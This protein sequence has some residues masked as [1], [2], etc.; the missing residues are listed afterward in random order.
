MIRL[1]LTAEGVKDTFDLPLP[2]VPAEDD[3]AYAWYNKAGVETGQIR[4]AGMT[5]PV[6]SLS[7]YIT[8]A[9]VGSAEDM[10]KLN[11]LAK[12]VYRMHSP[13]LRL[14]ACALDAESI[15]GL[16][17]VLRAADSLNSY[18]LIEDVAS[19]RELGGW[20]VE[21]G[22]LGIDFP[23]NVRPYL[24]YVGI[25]AEYYASHGGAYPP[26]GYV[27]RR[28]ASQE[29]AARTRPTLITVY[30]HTL[31]APGTPSKICC[32]QLPATD[33]ELE[34]AKRKMDVDSFANAFIFKIEFGKPY[35][36]ELIPQD[37]FCVEDANELALGMEE[38]LQE[39]GEFMKYLSVLSVEQP[40]T[41]ISALHFA[42]NIDDYERVPDDLDEYGKQ[43]LRRAGAD[44]EILDTIDGYMDFA[45]LGEDSMA[46]D[47]IRRTDFGL[48]RR[49]STPFPEWE[50][51]QTM[52]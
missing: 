32:L 29:Q 50:I 24:D 20:L 6:Y 43:V 44:D 34:E 41:L 33:S 38:M 2:A 14:F 36:E 1:Q 4:I 27:K 19:D 46:D 9:N 8:R 48:V 23:E 10:E 15:N 5:S 30:M 47:S 45:K 52:V 42:M 3:K 39:D 25:G 11:K 37:C 18:E 16:D 31:E 49:L 35:L 26:A 21:N 12:S 40:E 28:E 13:A 51:G 22:H 17:D 7:Q